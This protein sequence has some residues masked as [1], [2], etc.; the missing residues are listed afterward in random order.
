MPTYTMPSLPGL[1]LSKFDLSKVKLPKF[2]MPKFDIPKFD[3][4]KVDLSKFDIPKVDLSAV[5]ADRLGEIARDAVYV[6]VGLVALTVQKV[7]EAGRGIRTEL[8]TRGRQMVDA[9]A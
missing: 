8:A 4:P 5:D 3:F 9:V 6:G 2:E 1:D 7:D